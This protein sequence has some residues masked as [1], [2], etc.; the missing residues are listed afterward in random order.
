MNWYNRLFKGY[1]KC[2]ECGEVKPPRKVRY[3]NSYGKKICDSC[4]NKRFRPK[5]T[6]KKLGG[7][8]SA[9]KISKR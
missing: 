1:I 7:L 4:Y 6:I 3:K 5:N 9:N 2:A 8:A